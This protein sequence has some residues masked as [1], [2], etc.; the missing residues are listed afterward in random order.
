MCFEE[1]S[2]IL[3][4]IIRF[5]LPPPQIRTLKDF[6]FAFDKSEDNDAPII[7]EV[8]SVSVVAPSSK[9]RPLAKEISKSFSTHTDQINEEQKRFKEDLGALHGKM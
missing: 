7:F 6:F 4:I 2:F 1:H 9:E 3:S 8:K 5:F